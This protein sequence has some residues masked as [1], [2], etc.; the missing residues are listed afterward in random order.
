[1]P[2]DI[3]SLCTLTLN[4]CAAYIWAVLPKVLPVLLVL[5]AIEFLIVKFRAAS[6]MGT[7]KAQVSSGSM[8]GEVV[9]G[10]R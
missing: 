2:V 5:L 1:M 10:Q 8:D 3:P 7:K 6:S 9:G 4:A